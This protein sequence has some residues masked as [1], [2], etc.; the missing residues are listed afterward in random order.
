V[1][2][3]GAPCLRTT[4]PALAASTCGN[5]ARMLFAFGRPSRLAAASNTT[6]PACLPSP[7]PP[8]P[9][10]REVSATLEALTGQLR[11]AQAA[12]DLEATQREFQAALDNGG[13][14]GGVGL[15]KKGREP[16]R[17]RVG[18]G[19]VNCEVGE[20]GVW[21]DGRGCPGQWR[22]CTRSP[23]QCMAK[24]TTPA[25]VGCSC[26]SLADIADDAVALATCLSCVGS[27]VV[28]PPPKHLSNPLS[29]T[30]RSV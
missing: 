21:T 27:C 23:Q 29:T 5:C 6:P 8:P 10:P 25:A 13:G 14:P 1:N 30:H 24:H 15:M 7:P 16:W 28:C 19:R 9:P 12:A 26:C 22:Q 4:P 17:A 20:V 2:G 11:A 18:R 3:A